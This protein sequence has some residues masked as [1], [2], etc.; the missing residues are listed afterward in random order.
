M[1]TPRTLEFLTDQEKDLLSVFVQN[2]PMKEAL[3]KVLLD[4]VL[5]MGV[6]KKGEKSLMDRNFVF[7]LD[8]T[9]TM[10]DDQFGRAIR[11]HTEAIIA[12]EQAYGK[13]NE[14][15]PKEKEAKKSNPAL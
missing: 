5:H 3:R 13:L 12:I 10:S 15:L 4:E 14:L 6:S 8:P 2:E 9:G 7:G 11:V 1:S